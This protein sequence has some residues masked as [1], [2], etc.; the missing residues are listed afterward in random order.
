LAVLGME[1]GDRA[2]P[3]HPV[4][5]RK[6]FEAAVEQIAHAILAGDVE[7]GDRLPSERTLAAHMDISRPTL[8]EATK[9]LT[10][11]GVLEPRRNGIFVKSDVVPRDV[12]RQRTEMRISQ[13]ANVMELRRLIEPRVAQLAAVRATNEDLDHLEQMLALQHEHR[14]DREKMLS[15]DSRFHMAI[16]R[17]THNPLVV[18]HADMVIREHE[19]AR[20]AVDYSPLEI[21]IILAHH[22]RIVKAIAGRDPLEIDAAVDRHLALFE[23]IWESVSGRVRLRPPPDFLLIREEP[24]P[25]ASSP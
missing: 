23:E 14:A 20:E 21:D 13:I 4:R 9:V 12:I 17:A 25:P 5:T 18:T 15:L 22:E 8:R 7:V 10:Q 2:D 6:P 16:A 3:F 19:L 24:R 1:S 11:A